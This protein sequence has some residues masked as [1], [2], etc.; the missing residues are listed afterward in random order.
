MLG[1]SAIEGFTLTG[2]GRLHTYSTEFAPVPG[3][4]L[5]VLDPPEPYPLVL[6]Y[7]IRWSDVTPGTSRLYIERCINQAA[8]LQV[9]LD[10]ERSESLMLLFNESARAAL[11][12]NTT[13]LDYVTVVLQ[14]LGFDSLEDYARF[15]QLVGV[16]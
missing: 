5:F 16:L 2:A 10:G 9:L 4:Q 12:Y 11:R 6:L 3:D 15:K 1:L 14:A 13:G 8:P 7:R